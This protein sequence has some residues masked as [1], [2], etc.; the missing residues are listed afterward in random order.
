MTDQ[1]SNLEEHHIPLQLPQNLPI[2]P[3][4]DPPTFTDGIFFHDIL[5]VYHSI[6]FRI[7]TFDLIIR[8]TLLNN[9]KFPEI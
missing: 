3:L 7:F 4:E 8:E 9:S 6:D 2:I 5:R 1:I